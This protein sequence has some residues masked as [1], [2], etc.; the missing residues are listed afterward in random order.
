MSC[1]D[2]EDAIRVLSFY[3]SPLGRGTL[4]V[5]G[6]HGGF[7][8]A[9]LWRLDAPG[10]ALLL[11]AWPGGTTPERLDFIAR[12]LLAA[13]GAG[14]DFVPLPLP[15]TRGTRHVRLGDCLWELTDWLPG[16]PEFQKRP[17]VARLEA[18][19]Q[20]L[21]R[22]HGC[23]ANAFGTTLGACPAVE[24]RLER[25]RRWEEL[26]RSG[27]RPE[28]T[29]NDPAGDAVRRAWRLLSRWFGQVPAWL[30]GAVRTGWP[31]Q[32]CLCDPWHDHFLFDGERL[33]GLV[34]YGLAA[35][36]HVAVDL[37]RML[38][39]LVEDDAEARRIALAAYGQ[40]RTLTAS[41]T[42]LVD[43]LDRSGTVLALTTWL[44]WLSEERRPLEDRPTAARRLETLVRRVE[45]WSKEL[46][47]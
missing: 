32:P 42:E 26:L 29:D 20:A 24:R 34:D 3:P 23:W 9:R 47:S 14:L 12:L 5:L 2:L 35:V 37:A 38:G 19:A 10:G 7:S 41:E 46:Q 45:R 28:V 43:V 1:P 40:V 31:L 17:S 15:T 44:R 39:S 21:A 22:L 11:R 6:N 13:R 8:G 27:W 33:T 30:A 36:D 25:W 4:T 18:A 16:R